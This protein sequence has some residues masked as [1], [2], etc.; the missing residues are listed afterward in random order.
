MSRTV[1]RNWSSQP[2]RLTH[3]V[4]N[5]ADY[6]KE[7]SLSSEERLARAFPIPGE[8]RTP[9]PSP[10]PVETLPV[11]LHTRWAMADELAPALQLALLAIRWTDLGRACAA[12]LKQDGIRVC[13]ADRAQL[14]SAGL[15]VPTPGKG[16]DTLTLQGQWKADDCARIV[17]KK[18]NLHAVTRGGGYRAHTLRCSCGW[19]TQFTCSPEHKE[20]AFALHEL[21]HLDLVS[22]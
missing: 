15:S 14:R 4:F 6:Q 17:A 7:Q 18:Y 5:F 10:T 22:Q 3:K 9:L 12:K 16:Y 21:R 2:L 8:T 20:R 13:A 11:D 19:S 1:S